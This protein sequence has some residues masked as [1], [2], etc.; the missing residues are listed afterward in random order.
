MIVFTENETIRKSFDTVGKNRD[1][2]ILFATSDDL[3]KTIDEEFASIPNNGIVYCDISPLSNKERENLYG[4]TKKRN[5]IRIGIIDPTG[6]LPNP[7][8]LF[9]I[10]LADYINKEDIDRGITVTRIREVLKFIK[11]DVSGSDIDNTSMPFEIIKPEG[12]W[13]G[14]KNGK[15]YTFGIAY[16]RLDDQ[17][18]LK[19]SLG[20]EYNY[21]LLRLFFAHL[22]I[23][24]APYRGRLW[25]RDDNR[26]LF[27]FPYDEGFDNLIIA[28][29]RL[30]R[31]TVLVSG[32]TLRMQEMLQY[33]IILHLG[34]LEY[35]PGHE[36]GNVVSDSINYVN[37]LADVMVQSGNMYLTDTLFQ[38]IPL[39][40]DDLFV[41]D[42]TFEGREIKRLRSIQ[43]QNNKD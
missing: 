27:L 42:S 33:T 13:K 10:G 7:A 22:E 29:Y 9:H 15:E 26:A 14:I 30:I 43:Y 21:R 34:N 31:D 5:N 2:N 18:D 8:R 23:Y 39:E 1:F 36:S 35:V 6:K 19:K 12:G 40:I 24:L 11:C 38:H 17:K 4:L 41:N 32:E 20:F 16:I 28:A 37:H 25:I 3:R